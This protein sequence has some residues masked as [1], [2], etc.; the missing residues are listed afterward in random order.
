MGLPKFIENPDPTIYLSGNWI[1]LDIETTN[2][3]K[4]D[5]SDGDNY[6]VYGYFDSNFCGKGDFNN[7]GDIKD[8]AGTLY[9]ADFIVVQGGKFEL[10]WLK[11]LGIKIERLLIY[12]T[13]L[14]EYVIAGNRK[15]KLDLD[16]IS[17]RYGGLGKA[18]LVSRLIDKGVCPSSISRSILSKYCQTDVRETIRIFLQQREFLY[19]N[20][21]LNVF[22]LRCITTPVLAEI[23]LNGLYLDKKV[24]L[25]VYKTFLQ[26]H[27]VAL[28]KLNRITNGINMASPQQVAEFLYTNLG[29]RELTDKKGNPIRGKPNKKF[30]QGQ[31]LTDEPTLNL[32]SART[33]EQKE[34]LSLKIEESKLRK[35]LTSYV[36]RYMWVCGYEFSP[37]S[38]KERSFKDSPGSCIMHG[39][40][41]QSVA[42]THRLTSSDPNLQNIDRKLKRVVKSRHDGW[43]IRSADYKTLEF[44]TAGI[45][46]GDPQI[47]KDVVEQTDVHSFTASIIFKD[48]WARAGSTKKSPEGE[49]IRTESKPHTFKPLYGGSSGTKEEQDYYAAFREKY[50]ICYKTQTSWV[51]EVL[52]NKRLRIPSGL[53]FYW[54]DTEIT[55]SGW[56]TNT[57][58][59]FNYPIQSFAT[60]DIAPTGVCLLWHYLKGEGYNSFL[61]NEVHDSVVL[62]EDPRESERLGNLID[63]CLSK[64]VIEFLNKVLGTSID[65]PITVEQKSSQWWD[66]NEE[67]ECLQLR[68]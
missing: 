46:T 23:E 50:A 9:S 15:F 1:C 6:I 8:F 27:S 45:I 51:Y 7:E 35:K 54:P 31:P 13:L 18:S 44:S 62:E 20:G 14:G 24:V 40:L 52:Q 12:D 63:L 3:N 21:L 43:K 47:R 5:A 33:K 58:A 65:F 60:A 59:I 10:K 34:F 53:I 36:E 11:R 56:V 19:K 4:G 2:K 66:Y 28:Q 64:Y 67:T 25:D 48:E 49:A 26:E 16:S 22:F 57:N 55:K 41:N 42:Q 61:I 30:P 38:E 39:T 68:A 32:L 37:L 29:F 17:R